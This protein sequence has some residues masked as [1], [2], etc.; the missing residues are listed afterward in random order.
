MDMF[1]SNLSKNRE[2][3]DFKNSNNLL[4][5]RIKNYTIK[6]SI[7]DTFYDKPTNKD[8]DTLAK[9]VTSY[10]EK[11]PIYTAFGQKQFNYLIRL[12]VRY[13][14][15]TIGKNNDSVKV[16]YSLWLSLIWI[17]DGIF[18]KFQSKIKSGDSD[19]IINIFH[20]LNNG[21]MVDVNCESTPE[22]LID[23]LPKQL[24][25]FMESI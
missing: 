17:V 5:D 19:R 15:N 4:I 20:Q 9:K 11:L 21:V 1:K 13:A 24:Q 3:N 8:I 16:S 10:Y 2:D 12:S 6:N 25:L 22:N 14:L 23:C 7:I 18:D